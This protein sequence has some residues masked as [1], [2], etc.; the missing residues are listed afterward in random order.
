MT[1]KPCERFIA[2]YHSAIVKASGKDIEKLKAKIAGE[3]VRDFFKSHPQERNDINAFM[4][5]FGVFLEKELCFADRVHIATDDNE[6]HFSVSGCKICHG[7]EILRSEHVNT[8]CPI[9][10]TGLSAILKATSKRPKLIS[11][12][13]TSKVGDCYIKYR[14]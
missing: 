3:W 13:K 9:T 2:K 7:N 12:E 11:V 5:N 4:A 8:M 10:H 14:I 6:V 1:E